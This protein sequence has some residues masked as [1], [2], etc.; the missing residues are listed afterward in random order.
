M[1]IKHRDGKPFVFV[2][3]GESIGSTFLPCVVVAVFSHGQSVSS[4]Q[5]KLE[6]CEPVWTFYLAYMTRAKSLSTRALGF[7]PAAPIVAARQRKDT[8]YSRRPFLFRAYL[9]FVEGRTRRQ[10]DSR[11]SFWSY[12]SVL[13][14]GDHHDE[15]C[16]MWRGESVRIPY[17]EADIVMSCMKTHKREN[18]CN[19]HLLVG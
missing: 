1:T 17:L 5:A 4:H 6:K 18:K 12:S 10:T 2:P 15:S 14:A 9:F 7:F 19:A 16:A 8:G 3:S 13:H 11:F